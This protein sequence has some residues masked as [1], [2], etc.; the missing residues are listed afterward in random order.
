MKLVQ[1][2]GTEEYIDP[3]KVVSVKMVDGIVTQTEVQFLIKDELIKIVTKADVQDVVDAIHGESS[4]FL[5]EGHDYVLEDISTWV[6]V[7]SISVYLRKFTDRVI[8]ELYPK[9]SEHDL[10]IDTADASFSQGG[11]FRY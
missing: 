4:S 2:P 11:E 5:K 10:P 6:T 8:V 1:I 7:G 9:F 3:E